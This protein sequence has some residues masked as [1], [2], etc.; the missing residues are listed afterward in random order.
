L[1]PAAPRCAD[2]ACEAHRDPYLPEG[3]ARQ[4]AE[5]LR[6]SAVALRAVYKGGQQQSD[7]SAR[8]R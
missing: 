3:E 6:L 8:N 2:T 7:P 1:Q 4:I 5:R